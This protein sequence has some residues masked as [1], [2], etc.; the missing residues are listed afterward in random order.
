MMTI[1]RN[2]LDIYKDALA[3]EEAWTDELGRMFGVEA[4]TA[5]YEP[6]GTGTDILKELYETWRKV[7]EEWRTAYRADTAAAATEQVEIAKAEAAH[8]GLY[9]SH[10][11]LIDLADAVLKRLDLES[12]ERKDR[13]ENDVFP[14]SALR[15]DLR[16]VLQLATT[17]QH[18]IK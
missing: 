3:A 2:T 14:C 16:K 1:K 6:R 17:I 7:M 11:R 5:R 8:Q 9:K 13:G 4:G 10:G 12:K 15:T 18:L